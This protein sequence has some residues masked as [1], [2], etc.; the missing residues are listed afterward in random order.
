MNAIL[1]SFNFDVKKIN[2]YANSPETKQMVEN[3][4]VELNK[5][6]LY[7]TPTIFINDKVFVGPKPYRVYNSAINRFIFF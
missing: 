6:N 5:T 1:A 2:D 7:G 3:E 4:I